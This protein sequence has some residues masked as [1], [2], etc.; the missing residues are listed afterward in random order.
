MEKL[1]LVD[2]KKLRIAKVSTDFEALRYWA[3]LLCEPGQFR[4]QP[5]SSKYFSCFSIAEL[6]EIYHNETGKTG[7]LDSYMDQ[8][9][10]T[11]YAISEI[12]ED[13]TPV[14]T[15]REKLGSELPAVA[16]LNSRAHTARVQAT[17]LPWK[18][19]DVAE[20]AA[21]RAAA[22]QA[23]AGPEEKKAAKKK[24]E[25]TGEPKPKRAPADPSG[26]PA[27]ESKTGQVWAIADKLAAENKKLPKASKELKKLVVDACVAAGINGS[28]AGVQFAKWAK[29]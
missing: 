19:E 5:M 18:Q 6:C 23:A 21:R 12:Q 7:R 14:S 29:A 11:M 22:Q 16:D 27:A 10:D 24:T 3:G 8:L 9:R 1:L 4:I 20:E 25:P 15:L 28:T 17:E 26:R 2:L 13:N